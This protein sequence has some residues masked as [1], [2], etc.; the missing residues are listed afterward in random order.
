MTIDEFVQKVCQLP[1]D[2]AGDGN[3]SILDILRR[4]EY[5][6]NHEFLTTQGIQRCLRS[7]PELMTEWFSYSE[8]KRTSRGWYLI[9]DTESRPPR[10]AV[11]YFPRGEEIDFQSQ[12]AA[13]S[14]FIFREVR[15]IA[16]GAP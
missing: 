3:L 13:C 6:D 1:R 7:H 15:E 14:E 12:E 8:D 11:G 4:T 10:Y 9:K 5:F 2:F 16:G